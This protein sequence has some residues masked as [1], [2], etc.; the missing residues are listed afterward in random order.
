MR[1]C[2]KDIRRG[3]SNKQVHARYF[4]KSLETLLKK[5]EAKSRRNN[6]PI[7]DFDPDHEHAGNDAAEEFST[8]PWRR[9]AADKAT[10][11]AKWSISAPDLTVRYDFV[12]ENGAWKIFDL[13]GDANGKDAWSLRKIAVEG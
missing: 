12:Q 13:R 3:P 9:A 10:V 8:S 7:I 11:A 5:A 6:E 2:R 4:S 1:F